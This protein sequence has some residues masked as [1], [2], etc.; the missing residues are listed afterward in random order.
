MKA[1]GLSLLLMA[2]V[3]CVQ[4]TL[5]AFCVL[6]QLVT[7]NLCVRYYYLDAV[8]KEKQGPGEYVYTSMN[9]TNLASEPL[10]L[11]ATL[12]LVS[13]NVTA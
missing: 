4:P 8:E 2:S 3:H 10:L 1:R 7:T 11:T 13:R 5:C 9:T 12:L 6:S